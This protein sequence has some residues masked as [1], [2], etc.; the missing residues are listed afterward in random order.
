LSQLVTRALTFV[1]A[2]AAAFGVCG[3]VRRLAP[4]FGGIDQP[5]AERWHAD[6]RPLYGGI[7][8]AVGTLAGTGLWVGVFSK[9][10]VA[11]AG[12]AIA[13][14][15][16]GLV[17][18]RLSLTA[19]AKL[20]ATLTV[21]AL[22]TYWLAALNGFRP[23]AWI[24]VAATVWFAGLSHAM[25]LLDNMDGL[26]AGVGLIAALWLVAILSGDLAVSS[27]AL[28]VSLGGALA[29]FLC[30][31]VH[32]ARLFM[33]DCGS[34]FIGAVLAGATL[35]PL[36]QPGTL[37][38]WHGL[39]CGFV[40]LV[41]L[42]DTTFVL[43]LRRLAGRSATR[44]GTDHV[45]HR[46]VS[47]GFSQPVAVGSLW[48]LGVMGGAAAFALNG[49]MVAGAIAPA[50]LLVVAVVLFGVHLAR[51]P[52][53]NGR[54]FAAL[55]GGPIAPIVKDLTFRWRAFEV[56]LDLVLITV[57]YY[58]AYRLR[59]EDQQLEVF[60]PSFT[61]SLPI[62][63]ACTLAMFYVSGLYSRDWSAFSLDD[64]SAAVRAVFFGSVLSVVAVAYLFRFVRFSRGVFVIDAALLLIAVLATRAS[65]RMFTHTA[66]ARRPGTRRVLLYGAGVRGQLFVRQVLADPRWRM[67]PVVFLDDAP[68]RQH[69]RILDVWVAGNLDHL[70]GAL[71]R[72][73][74][75]EVVITSP[76]VG[77]EVEARV[78]ERCKPF[79]VPVRRLRL[80]I[81]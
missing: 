46:L 78:R 64:V 8:I 44:G 26:A 12:A 72:F 25:N 59:F 45:S 6:A 3:L 81:E 32:P 37:T 22:L 38:L 63:L 5:R 54:D 40:L 58:A 77:P 31:N 17:D 15:A 67:R 47:M 10:T 75:D 4:A 39:L 21:G 11:I 29:G 49:S 20:V 41:P 50:S 27:L 33:G 48:G 76:A 35:V 52:A 36:L 71:T 51:V 55:A 79:N 60:L 57:A 14:F 30:W 28:L 73:H 1:I 7:G 80:E 61:T 70:E 66:A 69:R 9:E 74:V 13:L 43:V 24:V 65:S 62:V 23:P 19:L 53:Y 16:V 2:A 34:L 18:D 42:F 68:V 56:L